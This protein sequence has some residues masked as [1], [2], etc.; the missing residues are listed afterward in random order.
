M[1]RQEVQGD[2]VPP[3][4]YHD[5]LAQGGVDKAAKEGAMVHSPVYASENSWE[6]LL[7]KMPLDQKK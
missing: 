3:K 5:N 2:E 1:D 7:G 4:K 6:V